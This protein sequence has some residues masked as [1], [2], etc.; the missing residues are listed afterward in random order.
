MAFSESISQSAEPENSH[1]KESKLFV[2]KS[3][4]GDDMVEKVHTVPFELPYSLYASTFQKYV[5][6]KFK[7][8]T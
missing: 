2:S 1:E 8:S 4:S 7:P 3:S 6:P 5:V